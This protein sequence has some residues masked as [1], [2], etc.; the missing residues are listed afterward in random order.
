MQV[1]TNK[2]HMKGTIVEMKGAQYIV[3]NSI[4][5]NFIGNNTNKYITKL[6]LNAYIPTKTRPIELKR[7]I[8]RDRFNLLKGKNNAI[9][10]W[11]LKQYYRFTLR[12]NNAK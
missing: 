12:L 1:L 9:Y 6:E 3:L 4:A 11:L 7:C 2:G 5:P 8:A 10:Y